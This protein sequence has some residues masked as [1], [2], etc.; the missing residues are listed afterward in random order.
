[1]KAMKE[2]EVNLKT[3]QFEKRDGRQFYK[4]LFAKTYNGLQ[5]E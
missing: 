2:Y 3:S 1:M 5:K 4:P